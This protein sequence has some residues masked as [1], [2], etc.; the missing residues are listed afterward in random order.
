MAAIVTCW[1]PNL[2]CI[3]IGD[4]DLVLNLEEYDHF[5]SL[6]TPSSQV[7]QPLT[8][9]RFCKWLAELLGLKTPVVDVL[10]QYGSGFGGSIPWDF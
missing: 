5:L 1:D 8:R 9:S 2:R 4:M 6:P 10:T 7:Y 3:I